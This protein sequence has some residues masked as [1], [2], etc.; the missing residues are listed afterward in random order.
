MA[1]PSSTLF[2]LSRGFVVAPARSGAQLSRDDARK[3]RR[4]QRNPPK[5]RSECSSDGENFARGNFRSGAESSRRGEP[6]RLISAEGCASLL[7][8]ARA[9]VLCASFSSRS[10][11][12]ALYRF[13]SPALPSRPAFAHVRP[14]QMAK[15]NFAIT[16]YLARKSR[17]HPP[18]WR[19]RRHPRERNSP[20]TFMERK[21][22]LCRGDRTPRTADPG[23]YRNLVHLE[24]TRARC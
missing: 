9:A 2:S 14:I 21:E 20:W 3:P 17:C 16:K 24:L 23:G 11:L 6:T 1:A 12:S 15:V 4:L 10:T 8:L 19:R 5:P 18:F 7:H 22:P 13:L